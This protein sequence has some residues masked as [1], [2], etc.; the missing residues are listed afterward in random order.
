MDKMTKMAA[1]KEMAKEEKSEK[2]TEVEP[3]M[4]KCPKCGHEFMMGEDE[5]YEDEE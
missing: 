3:H 1:I 2:Y 5:E 4:A